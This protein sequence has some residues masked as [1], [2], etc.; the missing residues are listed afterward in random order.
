MSLPSIRVVG[1]G[2][3][4]ADLLTQ[5]T[6]RLITDAPVVRLRTRVHPAA[7]G[8]IDIIS[9]DQWYE[10]ASSFEELY[11]AIV[12]DLVHLA[13]TSDSHEVLYVVPG[14]PIVAERTVELLLTRED[15]Q[16]ILEPAVSI[17]DLACAVLRRDPMAS[18]LRIV[19][20]LESI[21]P[22]RSPAPLLV[23]QTYS[24]EVLSVV[25]AR[26]EPGTKVTILHHLGLADQ[27][28]VA[29]SAQELPR[30]THADHLTSIWIDDL[31]SA[32]EAMDDLVSFTRRL[33]AEC[34]WDQEQTHS[35]LTRHLLEESYEA[36]DALEHFAQA[37]KRGELDD[38]VVSHVEE[39]LGDLLFQ[40]VFHA[41]LASEEELFTLASIA[42]NLRD[43]LTF[44]HPHVFGDVQVSDAGDV[45]SRWEVL[46][47]SEKGRDSVTDGIAMQLPALT[48]YNKLLAKST[49]VTN[50][51]QRGDHA[52]DD[53]VAALEELHFDERSA[54]ETQTPSDVQP[55]WEKALTSILRAAHWAGVDLEGV[56]RESALKMRDDIR[57]SES[58]TKE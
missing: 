19:D 31:R 18:N 4:D 56:L 20:A 5:R 36:L 22:F 7:G 16:V 44:R 52:R 55:A 33:R 37:Q 34:P 35:S 50:D 32:G 58:T 38:D 47:K 42:D 3:G 30:F 11:S 23:L 25:S 6:L 29:T 26:L 51:E 46:K 15:V 48:L 53:A 24:P 14:S 43:K 27:L 28:I 49:L 12:D 45:A 21:E 9:Y 1:L 17:I 10:D 40:I 8:L 39:E 2:P 54:N 41:E 13:L 57:R